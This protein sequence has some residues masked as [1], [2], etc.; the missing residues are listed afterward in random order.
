MHIEIHE[1]GQNKNAPRVWLQGAMLASSRFLPQTPYE[2]SQRDGSIVLTITDVSKRIVS[3]KVKRDRVVPIIDLNSYKVLGALADL[4]HVKVIYGDGE[5]EITPIASEIR[6]RERRERLESRIK[7]GQ[8]LAIGS[9]SHGGGVLDHALHSGFEAEG[10][11][12]E[13]AFANEIRHDLIDQSMTVNNVWTK[14]TIA[15]AAPL[16]EIAFDE[17]VVRKLPQVDLF[18]SGLPCSAASVAGRAKRGLVHPEA[19]PLVGHLVIGYLA[20]IMRTNPAAIVFE[21]VLPYGSSASMD[22]IRSQLRDM[23]YDVYETVIDGA[24]WNALE[25]RKRMVMV[26]VTKGMQFDFAN[27]VRPAKVTRRLGEILEPIA[28]DDPRWNPMLGLKAKEVRDA[29]AGKSFAMQ[30]FDADSPKICTLT[31]GLS[32]N[33]SSDAKVRHPVNPDLLRI[34]TPIEHARAK[35]CPEVLIDGLS[36][37][38]AHELLGQSVNYKPFV[39]VGRLLASTF[40]ALKSKATK[41]KVDDLSDLPL[42]QFA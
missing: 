30:I 12:C 22:I 36:D 23:H 41:S 26:A 29:E 20:L 1:V 39:S 31:K 33:R 24:D 2:V 34:P 9:V 28:L 11:K 21:Q 6:A 4:D 37:T 42:F 10:V 27:L 14:D 5:I 7:S 3:S 40:K 8:P 18:F 25:H 19:H 17:A 15:L 38:I 16:Q 13:L 35:D 32:R